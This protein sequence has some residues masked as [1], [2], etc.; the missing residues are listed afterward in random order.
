MFPVRI[1]LVTAFPADPHAPRG[2]VEAVSVILTRALVREGD[3]DLHVVTA[4]EACREPS[5]TTWAGAHI[6]RLPW[7]ARRMLSG[8]MGRDGARV[9]DYVSALR[10]D[11]VHAHD[12]YGIMLRSLEGPRGLTIH[13]FIYA[14]TRVSGERLARVRSYVWRAIETGAWARFPH[15]ISISPYVRARVT[16]VASGAIHD[17]D[18]PIDEAFFDVPRAEV[19]ARVFSAASITPRKNT[20]GL[21]DAFARVVAGGVDAALRLAGPQ[22][23][24]DYAAAVRQRIRHHGLGDRVTLLPSLTTEAVCEELAAARVVALVSLEENAPLTVQEAM[25]AGVPVV[26]SNR[27]GMPFQITDGET[28]FLVDPLDGA[29]IAARLTTLLTD[30]A[31]GARFG[32]RGRE[33]ARA[34]FHPSVVARQT[35]DVYAKATG[36]RARR[37]G[38]DLLED[39]VRQ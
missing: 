37:E 6:H 34:R 38:R 27:C 1:V 11:F 2:G 30:P 21:V 26:T 17:I 9:R 31:Q 20:V 22:P 4:D 28:G 10:P 35:L 7:T 25:A 39:L 3:I 8:A 16:G 32:A 36:L 24:A 23:K 13:G 18:N 15:L 12:T 29:D 5:V 14:D 19:G 33:V